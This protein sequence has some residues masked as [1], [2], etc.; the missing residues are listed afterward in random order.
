[1]FNKLP[2]AIL[3]VLSSNAFST[4][5][6]PEYP[7]Y[8]NNAYF[9][10]SITSPGNPSD[11]MFEDDKYRHFLAHVF[12]PMFL[13]WQLVGRGIMT[14][15]NALLLST[16]VSTVFSLGW[17]VAFASRLTDG[18]VTNVCSI[19]DVIANT[20]GLSTGLLISGAFLKAFQVR[21]GG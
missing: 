7:G 18:V 10:N 12:I 11:P 15:A 4:Y 1:M 16:M 21:G 13:S 5:L 9:C 3:L 8:D 2:I 17:E 6:G 19:P 20:L 14:P